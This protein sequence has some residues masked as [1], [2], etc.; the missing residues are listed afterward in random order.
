M[1]ESDS[2][3]G[4]RELRAILEAAALGIAHVDPETGRIR[5]INRVYEEITG[6]TREELRAMTFRELT[7]PDDRERDW[8]AFRDALAR[9][10]TYHTE[11][12]YLHKNGSTV[13]VRLHVTFMLGAGG[14]VIGTVAVCEDITHLR[15][16]ERE[17]ARLMR[18]VEQAGEAFILADREGCVEYVNPAFEAITGYSRDEVLGENPRFLQSGE[19]DAAHYA[20][21]W[22]TLQ[23]GETWRGRFVN[24]RKDGSHYTADAVISPVLD[25]AGEAVH[26][27][28]VQRDVTEQIEIADMLVQS[29]KLE[30]LGQLAGGVAHDFNNMLSVI[31]GSAELALGQVEK[32]DPMHSALSEIKIAARR[33]AALTRH[34]LAFARRQTVQP[35]VVDLNAEVESM[36]GMLRRLIGEDLEFVWRPAHEVVAAH[37]D[38]VQVNQILSNLC[39]NARDAMG[40]ATGRLTIETGRARF[41]A[42]YCRRNP[43]FQEGDF[44]LLAV[45]DDGKGMDAATREHIFEPFFTTKEEGEGTGLGL[46]SVYGAV[47]Q[48]DGFIKVYSEPGEGTTFRIYLPAREEAEVEGTP[49]ESEDTIPGGYETVLLVEDEPAILRTATRILDQL[50]YT[51]LPASSPSEAMQIEREYRSDLHLLV[52]DVVMPEMDGRALLRTIRER[53]PGLPCLFMSGYTANVIEQRGSFE[54]GTRFVQKPFAIRELAAAVRAALLSD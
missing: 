1:L 31:L 9:K 21:L 7:H 45:S 53:R 6:Y 17:R 16:V 38:P 20:A 41:D 5:R 34:L 23:R 30:S 3:E 52:T 51:V 27:V 15:H 2:T 11:K 13:W 8:E 44:V 46:A 48:N 32:D 40:D 25:D 18:A 24:Q 12:R 35:H 50:G 19:H 10:E 22:E 49:V 42:E 4:E 37:I 26:F 36:L 28:A 29:Q 47:R 43:G 54:P 33:S 14:E 39:V